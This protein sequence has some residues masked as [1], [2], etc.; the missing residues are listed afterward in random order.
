MIERVRGM[1]YILFKTKEQEPYKLH[2]EKQKKKNRK[3]RNIML[4]TIAT[5]L[6]EQLLHTLFKW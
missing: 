4:I 1:A 5:N 2:L 6:A 3:L